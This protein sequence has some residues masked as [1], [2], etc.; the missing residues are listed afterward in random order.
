LTNLKSILKIILY[1]TITVAAFSSQANAALNSE[2]SYAGSLGFGTTGI[3]AAL[4]YK[5]GRSL[6]TNINIGGLNVDPIFS[7]GGENYNMNIHLLSTRI[8]ED[9]YPFKNNFFFSAGMLIN[10]DRLNLTPVNGQGQYALATPAMLKVSPVAPYI[11]LG[12]GYPFAGSRWTLE[13][14]AGAAYEAHDQV[15]VTMGTGPYAAQAYKAEKTSIT[16]ALNGLHLYP[17]IQTSLVYRF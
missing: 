2:S 15:S 8:V 3:N 6:V 14:E 5:E 10:N 7:A 13:A 9:W 11:G 17:V 1:T 12:Y 4:Y 16:G